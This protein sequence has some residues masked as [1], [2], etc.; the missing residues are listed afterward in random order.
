MSTSLLAGRIA[1]PSTSLLLMDAFVWLCCGMCLV[2]S[3]LD[4]R[5]ELLV[6]PVLCF[7]E[8]VRLVRAPSASAGA[9]ARTAGTA[10]WS[11][12][13]TALLAVQG[14]CVDAL[15]AQKEPR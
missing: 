15:D 7:Y 5:L 2:T 12:S 14:P 11:I 9:A 10:R 8:E 13:L 4:A 3:L 6:F 1:P